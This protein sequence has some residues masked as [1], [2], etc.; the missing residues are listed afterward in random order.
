VF[1]CP[2]AYLHKIREQYLERMIISILSFRQ[3]KRYQSEQLH[4]VRND[5]NE[6]A[7]RKTQ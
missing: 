2:R 1:L 5:E 4:C 7:V 3:M 6:V